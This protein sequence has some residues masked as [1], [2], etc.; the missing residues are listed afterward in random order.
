MDDLRVWLHGVMLGWRWTN[1][2]LVNKGSWRQEE[3]RKK[4][5]TMKREKKNRDYGRS[6]EQYLWL[7]KANNG[8]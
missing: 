5:S 7:V 6:H 3:R 4:L 1:G 8:E 2:E